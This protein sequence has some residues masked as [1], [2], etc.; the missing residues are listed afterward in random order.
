V[1]RDGFIYGIDESAG[2]LVCLDAKDGKRKW[3]DGRF[4]NGQI[5]LAGDLVVIGTENGR[6]ALV[7]ANPAAYHELAIVPVLPGIKNWNHLT[8][9]RGRAYVRNHEV[10]ACYEL[11]TEK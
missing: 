8:L 10:M 6:L 11:P 1:Y 4:G 7:E 2:S 3:K 5:L 9:A